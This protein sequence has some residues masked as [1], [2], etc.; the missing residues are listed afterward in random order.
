[1]TD[2]LHQMV[3]MNVS[4]PRP[5]KRKVPKK[6]TYRC[7]VRYCFVRRPGF[8]QFALH[9]YDKDGERWGDEPNATVTCLPGGHVECD[10][11]DFVFRSKLSHG[12]RCKH[13]QALADV[14]LKAP[15][16]TLPFAH[17]YKD[18]SSAHRTDMQVARENRSNAKLRDLGTAS[19]DIHRLGR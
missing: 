2:N 17:S 8:Q 18:N 9:K 4:I 7:I 3:E 14:N 10:C 11:A 5:G 19:A 1:M 12:E 13:I 6:D 16:L 15:G